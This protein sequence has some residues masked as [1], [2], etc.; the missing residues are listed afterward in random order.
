MIKRNNQFQQPI[1]PA[2]GDRQVRF[3]RGGRIVTLQ[4][5]HEFDTR[6]EPY[7]WRI[8]RVVFDPVR[9]KY[10]IGYDWGHSCDNRFENWTSST[11]TSRSQPSRPTAGVHAC[12]HAIEAHP[13]DR[14]LW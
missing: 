13:K 6:G 1:A 7:K 4:T 5:F 2:M 14:G 8:I 10:H 3:C 12:A 11:G 9:F